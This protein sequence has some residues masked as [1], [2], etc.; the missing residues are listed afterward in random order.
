MTS[1]L[2]G[3]SAF[4]DAPEREGKKG[5]ARVAPLVEMNCLRDNF[6]TR[7]RKH[8]IEFLLPDKFIISA[9]RSFCEYGNLKTKK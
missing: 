8:Y 3:K 4:E 9:F 5:R 6:M 1:F 7:L 2:F